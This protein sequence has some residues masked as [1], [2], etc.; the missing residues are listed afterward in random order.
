VNAISPFNWRDTRYRSTDPQTSRDAARHAVSIDASAQRRA[1]C[2]AISQYPMTARE[3]SEQTGIDYI[4]VQRRISECGLVKT[5]ER[6]DGCMV[7]AA[8]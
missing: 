3:V 1:I 6:R 7:W 8:P 2:A 4:A 5:G